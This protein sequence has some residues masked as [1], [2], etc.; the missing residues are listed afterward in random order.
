M[1]VFIMIQ[2]KK[3]A[4]VLSLIVGLVLL[5]ICSKKQPAKQISGKKQTICTQIENT[6]APMIKV[7]E[8]INH[9]QSKQEL[10]KHIMIHNDMHNKKRNKS[11]FGAQYQDLPFVQYKT[12]LDKRVRQLHR[13]LRKLRKKRNEQNKRGEGEI[14]GLITQLEDL[15]R[16]VITSEEYRQ[17]KLALAGQKGSPWGIVKF[18]LGSLVRKLIPV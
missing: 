2:R 11:L 15:N 9:P 1:E 12:L 14:E 17:E 18:G 5:S 3:Q 7:T 16:V 4:T 13:S 10:K 6:Y 8:T